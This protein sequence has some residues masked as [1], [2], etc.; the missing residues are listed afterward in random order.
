M[1][2]RVI[3]NPYAN[4]WG[5]QRKIPLVETALAEGGIRADV[6]VTSAPEAAIAVAR[7]AALDG[8]DAIVAAGGDGTVSEVVNGLIQAAGDGP[9]RPLGVLPIGTGNDFSDMTGTPRALAEAVAVIAAGHT[10]QIDAGRVNDRYFDNNCALAME[11]M[12]TIE[13]VKI[14]RLSGNARYI[15]AL[16]RALIKLKAWQMRVTW[17]G[18]V[19]EGPTILLSVCNSPRTGGV[20]LMAPPAKMDDG[21]FDF[22]YA[23]EMSKAQVLSIL[24]KLFSGAHLQNPLVTHARTRRLVVESEPGTPIH[25][26]GEVIAESEKRV[27]Y[28]VLPQKITLLS[29]PQ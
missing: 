11:P 12:V 22:V 15:A 4:R 10:R 19:I 8:Y 20:F 5:A 9:T 27:E 16:V 13:N 29:R 6:T 14:K 21:L 17:D 28:E 3:L 18:G 23:P 2:V 26:D 24:P 7:Q 25:A 1:H